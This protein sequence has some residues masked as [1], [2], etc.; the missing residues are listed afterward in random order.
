MSRIAVELV[1]RE[2]HALI[3]ELEMLNSQFPQIDL[4]NIPDILRFNMRS[5]EACTYS[6]HYIKTI[7]HIRAIDM[8]VNELLPIA[9]F[10]SE[11]QVDEV[12][13]ISGDAPQDLYYRTYPTTSI[14]MI[15]KFKRELPNVKVY[16]AIDQYRSSIKDE[17][18]YIQR[19]IEA[20]ADGFFTQ[21][22]FSL[23]LIDFYANILKGQQVFFGVSP[24]TSI[25]SKSYWENRNRVVFP[26]DF[27]L[28][29]DWN[30]NFARNVLDYVKEKDLNVYFMPITISVKEYLSS[31]F[32][33]K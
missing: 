28:S 17:Y 31:V 6:S 3:E 24:V 4:V 8:D 27:D 20:G 23:E 16:A 30:V 25:K 15:K 21:P 19:K 2:K 33:N 9:D 10:L 18:D 26:S 13:I 29:L 7:P 11:A 22:F 14:E 5:W 1:P 12:L 32:A